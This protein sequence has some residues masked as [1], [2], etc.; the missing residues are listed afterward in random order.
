MYK[1]VDL[2]SKK[3]GT[4]WSGY[5]VLALVL[6]GWRVRVRVRVRVCVRVRVRVRCVVCSV[7]VRSRS[8]FKIVIPV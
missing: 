7:D 6:V 5:F 2:T 1:F 3:E 8:Y 4:V